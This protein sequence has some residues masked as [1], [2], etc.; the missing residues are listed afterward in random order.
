MKVSLLMYVPSFVVE[1]THSLLQRPT[2]SVVDSVNLA[3]AA[4][5]SY[6]MSITNFG[7]YAADSHRPWLVWCRPLIMSPSV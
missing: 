1:V 4:H 3:F 6:I 5:G 2:C 7:D